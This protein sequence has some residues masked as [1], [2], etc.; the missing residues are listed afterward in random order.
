MQ[1]ARLFSKPIV[2]AN[3]I[4]DPS[5]ADEGAMYY[6]TT[7]H[8]IH[9]YIN[10]SWMSL[11]TGGFATGNLTDSTSGAD[12]ITITGG[13]G[14]VLGGGTSIAQAKAGTASS[15]Y[16]ASSDWNSFNSKAS[17]ALNN[18]GATSIN[19]VWYHELGMVS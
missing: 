19:W 17:N 11:S 15:G 13:T 16:L 9:A 10:G 12:G 5:G 8:T 2:L 1:N 14:A 4:S 18:L 3:L 7:D 6:N